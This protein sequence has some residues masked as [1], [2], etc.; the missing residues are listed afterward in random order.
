MNIF[1][2]ADVEIA[3]IKQVLR[4]RRKAGDTMSLLTTIVN[5]F[6]KAV[7]TLDKSVK[8]EDVINQ[9]I[10]SS[11]MKGA[12]NLWGQMYEN[13]AY[14]L[15][16][17]T[18][19]DPS[20]VTSLGLPAFIASEKARTVTLEM[21]SEVTAPGENDEP[22]TNE[23]A[24]FINAQYQK[25]V[26]SNI[27]KQLEYGIAKGGLVI[28][29][30]PIIDEDISK[31]QF[32]FDYIQAD[33]FFPIAFDS[34]G[35]MTEAAFIQ[36]KTDIK[37]VYTRLEHHKLERNTVT[38]TNRAFKNDIG[39]LKNLKNLSD[40]GREIPLTSVPEWEDIEPLQSVENV[41]RLLFAYF[42][43][44]QANT[45]D[46]YS[47]LGVSGY[48]RAVDLIKDADKQ[49]SRL[50]WEFEGG[51]LA[52]DVDRTAMTEQPYYNED[53]IL[54]TKLAMSSLQ[55]RL[56]RTTSIDQSIG[57]TYNVFSPALRDNSLINGLNE[58]LK[59]IEDVTALSRGTISDTN[60]DAKTATEIISTKQRSYDDNKDIQTALQKT[61]E[62]VVYIMDVYCTLYNITSQGEYAVS[63]DWDDSI[64]TDKDEET[65]RKLLLVDKGLMTKIDFVMWYYGMT[66]K[67][68][69]AYLKE[70]E[71]EQ[72]QAMQ[73]SL[74]NDLAV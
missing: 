30:Y 11:A 37:H 17:P 48:S 44:P 51:E 64:I 45:I 71:T 72:L 8:I 39:Q 24:S 68:A 33:G 22:T 15:H 70:I 43:M 10:V 57:D 3:A 13:K 54:K 16:E 35:R 63:F 31:S 41:N 56:F 62:D 20:R 29:P 74:M 73:I 27:R 26:I 60:L 67:K 19:E 25:H 4:R 32:A 12:L 7:K 40:L 69:T 55:Q 9:A 47:P 58:I 21:K 28:K 66:R 18:L 5:K 23:R 14:W 61:L 59:R 34:S 53:G 65:S 49:Y 36:R 52:I 2:N 46:T 1:T 50:L 42:K 38:I 6:K